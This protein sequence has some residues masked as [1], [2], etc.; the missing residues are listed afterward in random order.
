MKDSRKD[1]LRGWLDQEIAALEEKAVR[2]EPPP[3]ARLRT[4]ASVAELTRIRDAARKEGHGKWWV[5]AAL[6]V[7]LAVVSI[8]LFARVHETAIEIEV[9][10]TEVSFTLASD[11]VLTVGF[12]P[13]R[14]GIAGL[15]ESDWTSVDA[16]TPGAPT[17]NRQ[18]PAISLT[19]TGQE[20]QRGMVTLDQA[21]IP[22][23]TPVTIRRASGPR[24]FQLTVSAPHLTLRTAVVGPVLVGVVGGRAG[25]INPPIPTAIPVIAGDDGLDIDLAFPSL[26][27]RP[28]APQLKIRDI[29]FSRI[30]QFLG[31][32]E[33]VIQR[34]STI[35]SGVMYFESLNGSERRLRSG[36]EL[37]FARSEGILR[38]I[39]L[40]E[41]GIVVQFHGRVGGMAT[42]TGDTRR[43]LMPRYLEWLQAR[44][45]LALLWGSSL[46]LFGLVMATLRWS[47]LR[48]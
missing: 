10:A 21:M 27:Q 20:A 6:G 25:V 15:S 40:T 19:V 18:S 41:S 31:T 35:V 44:H 5:A 38:A 14:L 32:Q 11:Q 1:A 12:V 9:T 13:S 2:G 47:G 42:G 37:R 24:D 7:T 36:E 29:G 39:Q 45:E 8:L 17:L 48:P 22:A 3:A 43:T 26:P 23:G 46:Y 16:G 30:D 28:I 4:L 33:S 34:V